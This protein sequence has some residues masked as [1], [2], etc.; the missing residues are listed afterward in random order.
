MFFKRPFCLATALACPDLS[1]IP[2]SHLGRRSSKGSKKFHKKSPPRSASDETALSNRRRKWQSETKEEEGEGK[3]S[4]G[5]KRR[6]RIEF[7]RQ[8]KARMEGQELERKELE[9]QDLEKRD[10]E[11]DSRQAA[12]EAQQ[13]AA[14]ATAR[15]PSQR[16]AG[17]DF[18]A[19][20]SYFSYTR[21]QKLFRG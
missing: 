9:R 8:E 16:M 7:E 5:C 10:S 19:W 14:S 21:S 6:K 1:A 13:P 11:E 20:F 18:S 17:F 12:V 4:A 3:E 15:S 2:S